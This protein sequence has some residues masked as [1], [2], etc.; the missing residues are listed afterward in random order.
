MST[1]GQST[2]AVAKSITDEMNK[3]G[4]DVYYDHGKKSE[5]VGT[6]AVSIEEALKSK[7][8]I[9]QLDIA[10][11]ERDGDTNKAIALIEIEE[12][13]DTPKTLIGD[14]FTT[15]RA[16]CSLTRQRKNSE[17]GKLDNPNHPW[18]RNGHENRNKQ[19]ENSE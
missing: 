2:S 5:F 8:Q 18:Q 7:N 9:S 6:I 3:R 4:I 14:I 1:H 10:V 11:V 16:I 17:G 19:I 12:T 13:T 15:V